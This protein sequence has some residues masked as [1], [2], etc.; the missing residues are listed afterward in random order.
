MNTSLLS[1]V[2]TSKAD[3]TWNFNLEG[4]A[5]KT[6][7]LYGGRFEP[8]I[9]RLLN[10]SKPKDGCW[11]WTG[12]HSNYGKYPKISL[13][14]KERKM[15]DGDNA[16]IGSH[17]LSHIIFNGVIPKGNQVR[18][19]CSNSNCINPEHIEHG[20]AK[21]NAH[22]KWRDNTMPTKLTEGIVRTIRRTQTMR[23]IDLAE[24]CGVSPST[25]SAVKHN[26][27]W[28]HVY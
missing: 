25:I 4:Q 8:V 7:A 2:N 14:Q 15:F 24:M 13:A 20:T 1:N 22:D 9:N 21:E 26:R 18:H 16:S 19:K 28:K 27:T 3:I 23:N 17:K 10:M 6:A 5:S 12:S 11:I